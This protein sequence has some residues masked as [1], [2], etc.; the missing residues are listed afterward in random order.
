ML[1]KSTSHDYWPKQKPGLRAPGRRAPA[2]ERG[3]QKEVAKVRKWWLEALEEVEKIVQP[4]EKLTRGPCKIR[5]N[6][7]FSRA[8]PPSALFDF[9]SPE[10]P[11]YLVG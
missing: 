1:R 4:E 10:A 2:E 11:R 5:T 3:Y 8:W 6:R 9:A 7:G